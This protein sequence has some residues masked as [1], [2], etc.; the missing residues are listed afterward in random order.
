MQALYTKEGELQFLGYNDVSAAVDRVYN[1]TGAHDNL[2]DDILVFMGIDETRGLGE[3][4]EAYWALDVTATGKNEEANKQ[5]IKGILLITEECVANDIGCI[6]LESKGYEFASTL[7]RA[8]SLSKP[9]SAMIAQA[10][11]IGKY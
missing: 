9:I 11:A 6:D 8:F 1:E 2:T 7:P 3:E 4:G 5:L 10:A